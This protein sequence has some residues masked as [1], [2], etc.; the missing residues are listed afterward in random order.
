MMLLLDVG[1]THTHVGLG[2]ARSLRTLGD[3]PTLAWSD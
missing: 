1:N 2:S 3:I